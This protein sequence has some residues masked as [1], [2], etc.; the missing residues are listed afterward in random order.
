MNDLSCTGFALLTASINLTYFQIRKNTLFES[1][2]TDSLA[3]TREEPS[4]E[5]DKVPANAKG[6]SEFR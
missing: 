4:K 3:V 1:L 5:I 6:T 2:A